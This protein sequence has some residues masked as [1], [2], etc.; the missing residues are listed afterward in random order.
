MAD[1]P[2]DQWRKPYERT[3]DT[4]A[5]MLDYL[6]WEIDLLGRIERDGSLRFELFRPRLAAEAR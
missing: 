2:V 5:A 6:A 3:A 1:E 4:K